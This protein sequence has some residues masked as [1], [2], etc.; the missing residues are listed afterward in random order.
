MEKD[1][2]SYFYWFFTSGFVYLSKNH[3]WTDWKLKYGIKGMSRARLNRNWLRRENQWKG[4][5]KRATL[6]EILVSLGEEG[7]TD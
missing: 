7:S 6:S 5:I 4:S 3:W 1:T 2:S